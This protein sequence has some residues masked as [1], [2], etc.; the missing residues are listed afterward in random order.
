M[1]NDLCR[2]ERI[3][4]MDEADIMNIIKFYD[5]DGSGELTK[6][7]VLQMLDPIKLPPRKYKN[8]HEFEII[9][10]IFFK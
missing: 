4:L 7:D 2:T 3:P 10:S 8:E 1:F 5:K 9:L 6:K